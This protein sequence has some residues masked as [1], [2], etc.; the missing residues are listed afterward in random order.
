MRGVEAAWRARVGRGALVV[1][2]AGFLASCDRAPTDP[3][4]GPDGVGVGLVLA[5]ATQED[6]ALISEKVTEVRIRIER[7]D[8][9]WREVQIGLE[10]TGEGARARVYLDPSETLEGA[11]L[12]VALVSGGTPLYTGSARLDGVTAAPRTLRVPV[13]PL[14]DRIVPQVSGLTFDALGVRDSLHA[15][16]VFADG[17]TI[18]GL[19]ATWASADPTV[20]EITPGGALVTRSNGRVTL[21][22]RHGDREAPVEVLVRQVPLDVVEVRP[23]SLELSVLAD[24]AI[25]LVG[26]DRNGYPLQGGYGEVEWEVEPAGVVAIT[27]TGALI[28]VREGMA[29]VR[30]RLGTG[31]TTVR[32][33]P[34]P[35]GR[36][37]LA[38]GGVGVGTPGSGR[39]LTQGGTQPTWAPDR[40]EVAFVRAGDL[41]AVDMQG[42]ERGVYTGSTEV[43]WPEFSADGS[44]IYYGGFLA[45][46]SRIYRIRP[47]GSR[48]EPVTPEGVDARHPTVSP[49]GTKVAYVQE[50][51]L[52]VQAVGGGVLWRRAFGEDPRTPSWSPDGRWIAYTMTHRNVLGF[53]SSDGVQWRSG[54]PHGLWPGFTWSPGGQWLLG[55]EGFSTATVVSAQ[56]GFM[57]D[58]PWPHGKAIDGVSWAR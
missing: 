2:L 44:W 27:G 51:D 11:E 33:T 57:Y 8:G 41:L 18:P 25:D 38:W 10:R 37:V 19:E 26:V 14:V 4:G 49:D 31:S 50:G 28:G 52:V 13:R 7:P 6:G 23:R 39:E 36:E 32:V 1:A 22:A 12:M 3:A 43:S 34:A 15:V 17:D 30:P 35:A 21:V 29:T 16:P 47:D 45:G 56:D 46:T 54:S 24:G 48:I 58:L 5:A 55:L 9:S 53:V 20:V 40:R 42:V